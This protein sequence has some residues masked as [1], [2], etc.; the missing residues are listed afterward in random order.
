MTARN[1][2]ALFAPRAIALIGASARE[3]SV[4]HVLAANLLAGGFGGDIAFVNPK[5]G[6]VL[7]RAVASSV[8]DLSTAP[9]LA[10][11]ATP[12]R[13]APG[14][15]ADLG[16]R[17]CRAAVVISAGFEGDDAESAGLRQA[18]LDAAR[19]H[20]LRIVGPNCLGVLSPVAGINA[21]FARGAPPAG[22]LALV[23]QSG[24]VAAAALDWAPSHGLGFSHV[25][26]LGD[27]LDVDVGDLLDFL[28]ADAATEAVL[29]YVE[30]LRD[31]RKFM[32]AARAAARAKPVVV[33]KGGRS[34]AG[35]KA[36]FSHTRA[37]AGAD[38]VYEAAFRRAGLV[39]V[40]GLD[41]LLD[42]AL[43]VGHDA[44]K[45]GGEGLAVLTNG[46][47]AAVLA[48]DAFARAGGSLA[49]LSPETQARLRAVCPAHAAYANPVDILGDA[50]PGLYGAALGGLL[51]APEVA[52]TLVI[53]CPTAVADSGE[54]ADAVIAAAGAQASGKPV[55]AA[56]LGEPSVAEGRRRLSA[57]GLPTF[58]TAETAVRAY[59]RLGEL[60]RNRVRLDEAPLDPPGVDV[61]A[62]RA[63]VRR[64][65]DEGRAALDPVEVGAVLAAYAIPAPQI[66]LALAGEV[67]AAVRA[68]APDGPVAVKI[69]S[70]DISHKSDVGG[71]R[72]GIE[73]PEAAGRAAEEMLARVRT[74]RPDAR[75][76][77]FLVQPMIRRPLA[78]EVL[79]GIV[80]DPT[81]G[82][83]VV[84]GHG[85]VAVEV[86]ADRALGLPPL[87]RVLARD[88]IARTRVSRLLAGYRDRPPADLDVLADILAALGRLAADLPEVSEL[89]L[90]P[91]LCDADGA[92]V[93]DARIAVRRPDPSTRGPAMAP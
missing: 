69:Q 49:P 60:R 86:L 92:V 73:G 67:E 70:P 23:A 42:V 32:R 51:A 35:A 72:L 85:G 76:T 63:I 59:A 13:T 41:E 62:A 81:F 38:A 9:D 5:G 20:L 6:E 57:A 34:T 88:M 43:L 48:V 29:L 10:V 64:A 22:G 36:A 80:R 40:D 83:V 7:G 30:S 91:V 19:P 25:V 75:V 26:T 84:V 56:W 14:L 24:A 68:M 61:E 3:G 27:A 28:A 4:G 39:Q 78:H 17:G 66:R 65:L 50:G 55:F 77:G 21:S 74:V 33:L 1:L 12:G 44:A 54:A 71:V 53:N 11:I 8:A 47:G 82:P 46:G 16:R 15:I 45:A 93:V 2:D 18:L 79:A 37:L 87:N 58:P 89:D 52:A 31:T 90:N